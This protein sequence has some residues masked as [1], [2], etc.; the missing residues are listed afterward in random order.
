MTASINPLLLELP[1][2]LAALGFAA[3]MTGLAGSHIHQMSS[4]MDKMNHQSSYPGFVN[5]EVTDMLKVDL[6]IVIIGAV[7]FAFS[8]F[9]LLMSCEQFKARRG[10]YSGKGTGAWL[11]VGLGQFVLLGAWTGSVAAYTAFAV[12]KEWYFTEGSTYSQPFDQNHAI[13]LRQ[14][15]TFITQQTSQN[16]HIG[17]GSGATIFGFDLGDWDVSTLAQAN[18]VV[19]QTKY[20]DIFSWKA[21]VAVGWVQV[22]TT[23]LVTVV[24]FALPFVWKALGLT[25]QPREKGTTKYN[26]LM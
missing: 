2:H 22:G 8:G 17:T 19:N 24:H 21:A 13:Y 9:A 11:V 23:F 10:E 18:A 15:A 14:I 7:Q 4:V 25:R 1:L 5:L 3:A 16:L 20:L 6:A 26:D 12:M